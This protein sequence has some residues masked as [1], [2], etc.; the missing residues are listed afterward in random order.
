MSPRLAWPI[1][2]CLSAAVALAPTASNAQQLIR[3]SA[4]D[5]QLRM[6][7]ADVLG[8]AKDQQASFEI[9]RRRMLPR[10]YIGSVDQNHCMIVGRWPPAFAAFKIFLCRSRLK[11]MS[12]FA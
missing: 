6:D 12:V 4:S 5:E 10:F 11:A 1:A 3:A 8:H 7:S 2:L 9:R